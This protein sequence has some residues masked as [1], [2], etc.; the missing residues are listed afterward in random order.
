MDLSLILMTVAIGIA[1]AAPI[2]PINLIVMRTA[3]ERGFV[4]G[5]A[6]G[7]GSVIGDAVFAAVAAYGIRKIEAVITDYAT[8]LGLAGGGL[9]VAVGVHLA[10][11]HVDIETMRSAPQAISKRKILK[12]FLLTMTNPASLFGMLA[13]FSGL[14]ANLALASAPHRPALAVLGVG[15]GSLIWWVVVA[16]A[17]TLVRHRLPVIWIDR[18]NRWTG[19]A[20]A[21]FGFVVIL[22]TLGR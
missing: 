13:L 12:T 14:S 11:A 6:A 20:I 4:P 22:E 8:I 5:V 18:I 17:V 19:I 3:L 2:G 9:L 15:L 1:V 21:A 10:K 16:G 7:L